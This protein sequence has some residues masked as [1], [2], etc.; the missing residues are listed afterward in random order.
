MAEHLISSTGT[1]EWGVLG[2][3]LAPITQFVGAGS[4][5]GVDGQDASED[6]E[7][8]WIDSSNVIIED[9]VVPS[10]GVRN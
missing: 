5:G 2:D 6:S 7:G 4:D 8:D 9:G 1:R 3:A 10:D